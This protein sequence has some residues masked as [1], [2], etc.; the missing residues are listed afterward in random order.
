MINTPG[1]SPWNAAPAEE[2]RDRLL[3]LS[4]LFDG[5]FNIDWLVELTGFKAHQLLPIIQAEVDEKA[6]SSPRPGVYFVAPAGRRPKRSAPGLED[7]SEW[8]RRIAVILIRDLPDDDSKAVRVSRHLL[9]AANDL[10]GCRWLIRAGDG[11]KKAYRT[12]EAF[13]C[14][15]KAL[16]DL[17]SLSDR[18]ADDLFT[19]TALKYAKISTARRD[20]GLV[21]STLREALQRAGR[22][23]NLPM[24]AL[25]QMHIAKNEWLRARYK[26]ALSNFEK[27]WRLAKELDDPYVL[28]AAATF[29][30]FFLYWQ[31][32]FR[33]AV[34]SYEKSMAELEGLPRDRFPLLG[35]ITLGYCYSQIGHPTQGL[36]ML[37]AVR[38][39][40]LERGD[41]HTAAQAVA[42]MGE[43]LLGLGR[44]DDGLQYL[45][46]SARLAE[47]AHNRWTWIVLQLVLGYAHHVGGRNRK[48]IAHLRNFLK[49]SRDMQTVVH[50]YPYILILCHAMRHKR[51][52]QVQG[53]DLDQEVNRMI[54]SSNI[55][56]KGVGYRYAGLLLAEDGGPS[57]QIIE[58]YRQST[59]W[60]TE[61]GHQ[62]EMART[63]LD[64]ARHLLTLGDEKQARE[65]TREASSVLSAYNDA[66]I[67]DD[68]RS[69]IKPEDGHGP[70]LREIISL[71]QQVA[72][73]RDHKDLMQQIIS[74]VNRVTGAERGAVFLLEDE[75]EGPRLR[76]RASKNLTPAQVGRPSFAA[77]VKSIS[78]ATR[79]GKSI[80]HG[81]EAEGPAASAPE[82][83]RSMVC[84]PMILHEK[85]VGVLY[86][87]NRLLS[88]AFSESDLDVLSYF[89]AQAAVALDNARAYEEISLLNDRLRQEKQYYEKEH[90]SHLHFD[91]IVGQSQAVGRVLDKIEQVA[92]TNASVL[93]TGETGV[94]K[95]LVARA[96]HRLS[97]R[98]RQS[99]ISV[100]LSSLPGN[101][102]PSELLGHEKGAFTG[103]TH[104]RAGR[105]ELADQGTLFLDEI[106]E[107]N[108]DIQ[109][110]LLRVLQTREFE[111]IGGAQTLSSDF[112]LIAA[113]NRDLEREVAEGRFRADLYYRLNV[114]PILVP[115]LRDRKEDV[116]L[117]AH[118][119]LRLHAGKLGKQIDP[120]ADRDLDR[121]VR[122]DW[123]G[124]VREL[125]NVIERGVI[126]S[127]G[128]RFAMPELDR[129]AQTGRGLDQPATLAENERRHIVLTL[130]KTKWK[131]AGPD[132]AAE[133]LGLP[134]STLSFRMKKLGIARPE[135][136]GRR[137]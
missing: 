77:S 17:G 124:N 45:E 131:V 60:L 49:H 106:G 5:E 118:H 18:E 75:P 93:I 111:R 105:F 29:S 59:K 46:D 54:N 108:G 98:S 33:E 89:A 41:R 81:L 24:T 70:L 135:K 22:H 80:I 71:G 6:L 12:E 83:I 91:E 27:G 116:P 66:L 8:R 104:R 13:Q 133:I 61:S 129:S 43:I 99:F 35:K 72:A 96:I 38:T 82:A 69:M 10:E 100:Q 23:D 53:L 122:Y 2:V 130:E 11:H 120:I 86:H 44:F 126:L 32:R 123:P 114:F 42:N 30:T 74:T 57:A 88:S 14:Y 125:E 68:L 55:F 117:L 34:E 47:E 128:R 110:R 121:L 62:I 90:E 115:P 134:P 26:Q 3:G 65:L 113:T 136:P 112:R 127:S 95:E 92:G 79:T 19:E 94:G 73:I 51:L 20:T 119:F 56:L 102:V 48:A 64:L 28:R 15:N 37:D 4:L 1:Q 109:V 39:H 103:A 67:P 87:D 36:G 97:A 52:P 21:L 85:V 84:V 101:L 132:G 16:E 137:G 107:I 63:R 50:L 40:C 76:L 9:G 31:G 7:E 58:A 78:E 25:L